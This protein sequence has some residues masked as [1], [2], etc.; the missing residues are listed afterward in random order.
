MS[1]IFNTDLDAKSVFVF[2]SNREGRH[3]KGAAL[4]AKRK[5]GAVYGQAEGL[6]G[7]SYA[8]VTK[9]LRYD[10]SPITLLEIENGV[11]K[12]IDFASNKPDWLF[13]VSKIG[14][15]LA[16]FTP[17]QIA[18]MFRGCAKNICLPKEFQEILEKISENFS[19][20]AE[21]NV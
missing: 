14:C 18:P 13:I 12:F 9:E 3:G 4:L 1:D 10:Q 20:P 17:E 19:H 2:G 11:R 8:I 5:W 7:N 16:V 6:Q 15:G 21:I